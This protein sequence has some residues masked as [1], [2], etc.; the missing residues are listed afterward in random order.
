LIDY[1][2]EQ[3]GYT[4]DWDGFQKEL[5]E[6]RQRAQVSW[7][8]SLQEKLGGAE[9]V[10]SHQEL[11]T[12]FRGY[13]A[14]ECE[15]RVT[16]IFL[17]GRE[18]E[19]AEAGQQVDVVLD[20]T[21]FYAESGGQIGD[22]GVVESE[23]ARA[24]VRD[25]VSKTF[26]QDS[27]ALSAKYAHAATVE[28]GELRVGDK[29]WARIDVDRRERIRPHHT[30]THLVHAA[31]R[32]VLGLH[33]KQAGSLVAPDRL[34]FDFT[35]FAPL[36]PEEIRAIE[37]SVNQEILKNTEVAKV[38]LELDAALRSGAIAFFGEKY[39][40]RVRVVEVPGFS[41][42]LCGGTHVDRTGDIGVFKI[43]REESIGAGLRRIE[44]VTGRAA[45]ERFQAV[46]EQMATL[47]EMLRTS[48]QELPA[49]I[50]RQQSELKLL[51]REVETLRL[52][53][54]G[55]AVAGA[56]ERVRVISGVKV[57]VERVENLDPSGLRELADRLLNKLSSGVIVLGQAQDGKASLVVRVSGDL[58]SR[59]HAGKVIKELAAIVGGKG[60]GRPELA[61]AGG[62]AA[63]KL[64]EALEAAYRITA[65]MLSQKQ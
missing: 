38:E 31:L 28:I 57:L 62:R 16:H 45:L 32:E 24:L 48:P 50:E 53:L 34:R 65:E 18:V 30:A 17:D 46:E 63:E 55:A 20:Q 40:S 42:E 27:T 26:V 6:Q 1:I 60:G 43:V 13:Q 12:Q 61:E 4:V 2:A 36:T 41:K 22:T 44:A 52:K 23:A 9:T 11:E 58:T 47:A 5:E 56:L 21:P 8:T 15:A 25:T 14:T 59:L 64:P 3:R 39:G 51:E 49:Q 33:V 7:K 37:D 35:H 54:A 29:V 10:S 19:R